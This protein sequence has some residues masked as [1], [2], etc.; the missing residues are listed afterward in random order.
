[1]PRRRKIGWRASTW[2]TSEMTH[3]PG[4]CQSS[5]GIIE[6]DYIA[7]TSDQPHGWEVWL[8]YPA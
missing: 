5:Q 4:T 3:L 1:M 7:S 8:N 6:V 2:V